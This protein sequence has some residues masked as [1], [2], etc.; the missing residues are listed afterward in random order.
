MLP[1]L[2]G[3]IVLL[4]LTASVTAHGRGISRPRADRSAGVG[5]HEDE[6]RREISEEIG[7]NATEMIDLGALHSHDGLLLTNRG[8]SSISGAHRRH[9]QRPDKHEAIVEFC[10]FTIAETERKIADGTITDG[11]TLALFLRGRA[12]ARLAVAGRGCQ[13]L[14]RLDDQVPAH[15]LPAGA[16][17]PALAPGGAALRRAPSAAERSRSPRSHRTAFA[18]GASYRPSRGDAPMRC[19]IARPRVT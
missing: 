16:W 10:V 12:C 9:R 14:S 8:A 13:R 3:R 18:A 1:F 7:A 15:H 4:A 5:T 6:A 19:P 17:I 11:P 2:D